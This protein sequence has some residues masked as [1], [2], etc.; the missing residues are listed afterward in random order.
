MRWVL[1]GLLLVWGVLTVIAYAMV[2]PD[3]AQREQVVLAYLDIA[4]HPDASQDVRTLLDSF[5]SAVEAGQHDGVALPAG[6]LSAAVTLPADERAPVVRAFAR[7]LR[8]AGV[9]LDAVPTLVWSTDDNPARQTQLHLFRVWHLLEYGE[10]VDI[11]PDP[12]NRDITKAIVQCVAGRG[13]DIIESY[14][15]EQLRQFVESGVALDVTERAREQGFAIDRAFD[16]AKPSMAT[17]ADDGSWR[18]FAFPCN[19]GYTVLFYH[20][21][22][23]EDAGVALPTSVPVGTWDI[24]AVTDLGLRLIEHAEARGT[25]RFGIMNL[26]AWDMATHAGGRFFN[27][28]GTA[29]FYN[30]RFTVEGLTAYHDMIYRDGVAPTPA[31]AASV[32]AGGGATMNAEAD[33]A[34]ASSLFAAKVAAMYV[35]GRW[36]Y[37]SL[38]ERNR[39]RVILPAIDRELARPGIDE[40]LEE[41][42]LTARRFLQ[43]DVLLPMPVEAHAAMDSILTEADRAG[44]VQLGIAH[45]PSTL[46][47]PT[48]NAGA[49]VAIVN[50]S[51]QNVDYA[52]RFLRFLGSEAYN[53]QINGTYDSICGVVE[54]TTDDNGISGPPAPL[55]GLEAMDSPVFATAMRD[56]ARSEQ[57][58][59]FITR[60]RLGE[61]VGPVLEDLRNDAI[62]PAQAARVIEKRVND[63]IAANLRRDDLLRERWEA[64]TGVTFDPDPEIYLPDQLDESEHGRRA[65]NERRQAAIDAKRAQAAAAVG[66][67]S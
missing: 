3:S 53:E 45:I 66:A 46:G 55:P 52:L 57:V 7:H 26:G 6:G 62:G 20:R 25:R 4:D 63:Q 65:F 15:P 19:V 50:R 27:E 2:L 8:N 56:W 5:R 60:T 18:Q 29:S 31:E 12:S 33:A 32:A 38:A 61:L 64:V 48:Y 22:L 67:A 21:D 35:G 47:V 30:S 37:K 14:G 10:P 34:S 42:L 13:P 58:S 39:D 40:Y 28:S 24:E 59:P 11:R 9:D 43:R 23:F 41:Q 51:G 54:Y 36:E 16:A 49:R 44:L 1:S 17:R